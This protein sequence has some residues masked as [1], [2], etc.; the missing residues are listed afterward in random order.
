MVISSTDVRIKLKTLWPSL[1]HIW[2]RNKKYIA[3]SIN[4]LVELVYKYDK[5][6]LPFIKKF[7][8]CENYALFLHS[9]V[10]LYR[11]D[12]TLA[13][14]E[15]LNWAFGDMLCEKKGLTGWKSH[16]ANICICKEGIYII[17]PMRK[18]KKVERA[19][20]KRYKV[21]YINLM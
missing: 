9:D 15:R 4:E 20:V 16:T 5:S 10:K 1:N 18:K 19:N 8:E 13:K 17:E 21:F 14:Q 12:K 6:Y 11:V 7:N 3:P 2:L